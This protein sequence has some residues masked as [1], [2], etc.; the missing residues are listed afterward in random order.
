M[1]IEEFVSIDKTFNEAAFI[2]KANNIFVKFF[3]AIMM[4]KLND[5][6][7]F[8][9]DEVFAYGENIIS[10]LREKNYRK[11][12]DE[13]NVKTSRID[14]IDIIDNEYIINVYL[15]SR[16]MDYTLD[17]NTGNLVFGNDSSRIQVDYMLTFTK[18]ASAKVQGVAKS[19]PACGAPMNVNFSGKCDYCGS[20]YKQEDYDWVLSKLNKC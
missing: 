16:Y 9:S 5:V 10:P 11:M 19:C 14:S 12:Y 17:L 4:D 1:T 2:T 15:Q 8:V 6:D 3:T 20:I 7:H 18:K 13:L